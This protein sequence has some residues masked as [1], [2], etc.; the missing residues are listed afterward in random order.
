MAVALGTVLLVGDGTSSGGFVPCWPSMP[1]R[2]QGNLPIRSRLRLPWRWTPAAASVEICLWWTILFMD[3][4][5]PA[6][7]IATVGR[8]A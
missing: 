3:A 7:A 8:I 6:P 4:T 1:R 5:C 2:F